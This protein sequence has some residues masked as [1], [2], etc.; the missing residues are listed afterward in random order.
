MH[1]VRMIQ[2]ELE[3]PLARALLS[4]EVGGIHAYIVPHLGAN[5]PPSTV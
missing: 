4:G 5:T 1:V 3:A 2:K